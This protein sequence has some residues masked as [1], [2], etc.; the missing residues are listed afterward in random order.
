MSLD[1]R[2]EIKKMTVQLNRPHEPKFDFNATRNK[3]AFSHLT[4]GQKFLVGLATAA[5]SLVTLG[6]AGLPMYNFVTDILTNKN[7]SKMNLTQGTSPANNAA[8]KAAIAGR[9]TLL[10]QD[11]LKVEA[12]ADR[13]SA[14]K[15]KDTAFSIFSDAVEGS[16]DEDIRL[17]L[18]KEINETDDE[19]KSE[20]Y[21]VYYGA[22]SDDDINLESFFKLLIDPNSINTIGQNKNLSPRTMAKLQHNVNVA[23]FEILTTIFNVKVTMHLIEVDTSFGKEA[24]GLDNDFLEPGQPVKKEQ[25]NVEEKIVSYGDDDA[26][27][28]LEVTFGISY[29]TEAGELSI[30]FLQPEKIVKEQPNSSV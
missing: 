28:M 12:S 23:R 11:G 14:G 10:A 27:N 6:I 9:D 2:K 24:L 13:S 4:N 3:I 15:G 19:D 22:H 7:I 5:I 18:E 1:A 26:P 21:G 29:I 30:E 25:S 20:Y 8:R 17:A 16:T